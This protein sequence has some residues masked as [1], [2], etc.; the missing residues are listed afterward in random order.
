MAVDVASG[1]NPHPATAEQAIGPYLRAILRHWRLVALVT[2][3]AGLV[4]AL[5]LS[6]VGQTYESSASILITPLPQGNSAFLGLP[7][8]IDTADP[9]RTVQTAAALID[10]PQAAAGAA[11]ALGKPWTEGS[12]SSAVS[13][14]PRG[15]SD[16]IAVTAD[17]SG[18]ADAARVAN[19]YAKA[20]IAYRAAVVQS[21][22]A[23]T[24]SSLTARLALVKPT[25]AEAQALAT[26]VG[27]LRTIQGK[28]HEP[29]MS[30]S[31]FALPASSPTGAPRW[32][33]IALA[34]LGGLVLGSVAA[35]GLET[36]SRP[37]RDQHEITTL[38]PA[39][40]LATIPLLPGR[41]AF[42]SLAPWEFSPTA[43][44]QV[45][46]LRVQL[47]VRIPAPVIMVTSA[48]AGDGKTTV[49][50]A[51]AAAFAEIDEDVILMDL[52]LRKPDL[53]TVLGISAP[54][55]L[56]PAVPNG[57]PIPVPGMPRVKVIP[58]PKGDLAAFETLIRRL[59]ELIARA[60]RTAGCVIVDT[61]PV[62]EV[63]EALQIAPICNQVIF[64]ARPRHTDRRRLI[65]A[66]SLL[67]RIAAPT[68]GLVLVGQEAG[69]T[70]G[71]YA[72]GY[73][74]SLGRIGDADGEPAVSGA[75]LASEPTIS[76]ERSRS[77]ERATSKE[78][79]DF[80]D[81]ATSNERSD[82]AEPATSNERSDSAEPATS[83]QRSPESK[84]SSARSD[85]ADVAREPGST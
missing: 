70:T 65:L 12:V 33:I 30:I 14:S 63:S 62:G 76:T 74:M 34:L 18:G 21:E 60:Q 8:V 9:A 49:A 22:I 47:S 26:T 6:R 56:A 68:T 38:F 40:I 13:V 1:S 28:G 78:R 19:A 41:R 85:V 36:F 11:R 42:R 29:T 61:A 69:V 71:E 44:E 82:S 43:F 79:S 16:V 15:A 37:V 55:D 80:A 54:D 39:P 84:R 7:T 58:A 10:T 17:T 59:P 32:L 73:K 64:V 46:M 3:L 31:Q 53:T 48:G 27:Q 81:P 4:A 20:A 50:A 72:Y 25:S 66:R 2:V 45:R 83:N 57:V 75:R 23:T 51:L 35:V 24:L 67:E 77:A 52:D 5:T